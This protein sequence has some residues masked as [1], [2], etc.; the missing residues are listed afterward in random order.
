MELQKI[1]SLTP[2][3]L[4]QQEREANEQLFRQRFQSKLGQ[5]STSQ[6]RSLR[7][8][9]ARMKTITRERELGLTGPKSEPTTKGKGKGKAGK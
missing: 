3:E 2:E 6:L 8:D 9:I 7:K 1:R 5:S 4:A